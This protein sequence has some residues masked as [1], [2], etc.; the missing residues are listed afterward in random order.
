MAARRTIELNLIC[1]HGQSKSVGATKTAGNNLFTCSLVAL[2][3]DTGKMVWY[4]PSPR[5]TV[6]IGIARRCRLIRW[7][8]AR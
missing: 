2:N 7:H 4:Y 8:L 6:T 5:M 1:N 3:A